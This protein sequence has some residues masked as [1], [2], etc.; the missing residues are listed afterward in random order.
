MFLQRQVKRVR[1]WLVGHD[2]V[3]KDDAARGGGGSQHFESVPTDWI[4]NNPCALTVCDGIN[5]RRQIF[6]T[7]HDY[8][9]GTKFK[10]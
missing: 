7:R 3:L 8:M 6:I 9:V 1:R 2:P 4:E 5:A 10:S